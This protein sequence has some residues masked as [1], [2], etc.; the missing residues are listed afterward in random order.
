MEPPPKRQRRTSS[1]PP[2]NLTVTI[3]PE[4]GDFFTISETALRETCGYFEAYGS[5]SLPQHLRLEHDGPLRSY[6]LVPKPHADCDGFIG[7]QIEIPKSFDAT[8]RCLFRIIC[9]RPLNEK[10]FDF[11]FTT[12]SKL[13]AQLKCNQAI[14]D[15]IM[16]HFLVARSKS[17]NA[18]L[19][20]ENYR[21]C[22]VLEVAFHLRSKHFFRS[23]MPH[24]VGEMIS[25]PQELE[26]LPI[27]VQD[28]VIAQSED[29]NK[30]FGRYMTEIRCMIESL[31]HIEP[32]ATR[33]IEYRLV[34]KRIRLSMKNES[35]SNLIRV[36]R[37]LK[38]YVDDGTITRRDFITQEAQDYF[39]I[40]RQ[41]LRNVFRYAAGSEDY[42]VSE[43][44]TGALPWELP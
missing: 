38:D 9:Q 29:A 35:Q 1:P 20:V 42:F 5:G 24:A 3:S 26:V 23:F 19:P 31:Y 15:A 37:R 33:T 6:H 2:R 44:Y 11:E 14:K 12:I 21:A 16:G 41:C 17:Q 22:V 7:P 39:G 40:L 25:R 30:Q 43:P 32:A 27:V 28:V 18:F 34:L 36:F 8:F 10:M 13:A 4:P